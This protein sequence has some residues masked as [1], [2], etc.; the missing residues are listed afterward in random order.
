[1]APFLFET[2]QLYPDPVR[3]NGPHGIEEARKWTETRDF[4]VLRNLTAY[5]RAWVVHDARETTLVRDPLRGRRGKTMQEILY[6]P[7]PIWPAAAQPVYDPRALAWVSPQDLT[8]I[9]PYLSG[10]KIGVSETVHAAYPTPEQ[11]VLEVTLDSPGLVV[12]ADVDYPGW[13]L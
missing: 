3:F 2:I 12:L 7:D 9:R 10:E 4:R 11:A 8:A 6:A 1:S 5:P 13:D